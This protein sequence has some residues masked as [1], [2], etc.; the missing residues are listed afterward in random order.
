MTASIF[1]WFFIVTASDLLKA[2]GGLS[3]WFAIAFGC[4][5]LFANAMRVEAADGCAR[6][7]EYDEISAVVTARFYDRTFRG[8]AWP[9]RVEHYR[10]EVDC[11]KDERHLA[12][13]VNRL[14]AELRASHTG[15]YTKDDLEY[16]A[17]QSV[18]SMGMEKYPVDFSGIWPE[19]RDNAWYA[20]YVVPGTPAAAAGVNA[21]DLLLALDGQPF[22]TFGF[23]AQH[24]S[25][26]TISPDGRAQRDVKI[27]AVSGSMQTFLLDATRSSISIMDIEGR[28]VG[29][30]HL[31]SGTHVRF[32]ETLNAA[33]GGF[34]QLRVD[35]VIVDLRGGFGGAGTEYLAQIKLSTHLMSVPK[36]FLTDDG[37]R[38]G[39]EWVAATIKTQRIGTLVGSRTAGAFLGGSPFRFAD[40]RY[41]LLLAVSTFT[42]PGIGRIEG[43]G[44]KPDVTVAPC[45][46]FCGGRDPQ[47]EKVFEL[48]RSRPG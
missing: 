18:F 14:L 27:Q 43:I 21:G 29:Y 28:K 11:G 19:R 10:A 6:L 41:L 36:Y 24:P 33:L 47:L 8:L 13:V 15:L 2:A 9:S 42:P 3:R 20:K 39:K 38:S 30:V 5:V 31:W 37:T 12:G 7:H 34:D 17:F 22:R 45:R 40:E 25:I 35:A 4:C 44:V 48:I 32:L 23:S 1:F 46:T 26:L 16:W